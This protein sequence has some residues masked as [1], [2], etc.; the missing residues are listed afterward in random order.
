MG[1]EEHYFIGGV[2]SCRMM[3]ERFPRHIKMLYVDAG[4][5]QTSFNQWQVLASNFNIPLR[6]V[7]H[8]DLHQMLPEV[9][10][11]GVVMAVKQL[12]TLGLEDA[13]GVRSG[14]QGRHPLVLIL[15]KI[16]DPR[17]LG[18]CIR[19]AAAFDVD[20]VVIAKHKASPL[21]PTAIKVASGGACI[22]PVVSMNI[23]KAIEILKSHHFWVYAAAEGGELGLGRLPKQVPQAWVLGHEGSGV[24]AG[25]LKKCDGIYSIESSLDFSTLNVSVA[26]GVCLYEAR[27]L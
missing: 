1:I 8:H 6:R 13:L 18:A 14:V 19:T 23:M 21:T 5:I 17:N 16:Q 26:A 15:D 24:S 11:Q 10:S 27:R 2:H 9:S 7:R 25:V 4:L 22:V 12:P 20:C 3:A